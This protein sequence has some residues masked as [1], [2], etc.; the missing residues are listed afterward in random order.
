MLS[1]DCF[2]IDLCKKFRNIQIIY[3]T[4][5]TYL[6]EWFIAYFEETLGI[7]K[8]SWS[9]DNNA[10][11]FIDTKLLSK[12]SRHPDLIWHI[13]YISKLLHIS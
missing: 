12:T 9:K 7:W 8:K 10:I 5:K 13:I 2:P 1:F 11:I 3:Y 4:L 6:S